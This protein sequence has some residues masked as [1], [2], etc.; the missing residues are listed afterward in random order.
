[1]TRLRR[2]SMRF[3]HA[4]IPLRAT[5]TAIQAFLRNAGRSERTS[6][7]REVPPGVPRGCW[8]FPPMP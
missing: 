3:T 4:P 2:L 5:T 8:E 6:G 7:Y 1:M